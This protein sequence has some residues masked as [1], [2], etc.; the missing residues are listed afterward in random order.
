VRFDRVLGRDS[1][2]LLVRL[3]RA[4]APLAETAPG[5]AIRGEPGRYTLALP[6]GSFVDWERA[7][8]TPS[9]ETERVFREIA[10]HR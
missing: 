6:A 2:D 5:L 1:Q 4:L 7:G 8:M 3:R 10:G 9:A